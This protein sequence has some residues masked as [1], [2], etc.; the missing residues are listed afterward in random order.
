MGTCSSVDLCVGRGFFQK[1]LLILWLMYRYGMGNRLVHMFEE[2]G[3]VPD[4]FKVFR[5]RMQKATQILKGSRLPPERVIGRLVLLPSSGEAVIVGDLH[6]DLRS[7]RLILTETRFEEKAEQG[8]DVYLVCLGDYVDRGPEQIEVLYT[9]LGLLEA[10]P[11]KVFLFRGN[12]EGPRDLAVSPH[13]FP[14]RLSERYGEDGRLAYASV[15]SLFEQLY[16]SAIIKE[17]A[18]LVHGGI[19]TQASSLEDIA[20]AHLRH[21]GDSRLSEMLWNDPSPLPGFTSSFRGVG[22]LFGLDVTE[23]FLDDLGVKILIRGHESFAE[24]YHFHDGLILSLFSCK[25]PQ[26]GNRHGAYLDVPLDESF[27]AENLRRFIHLF[28]E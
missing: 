20:Y 22:K 19:P 2:S 26:Y 18:F 17:R 27:D 21:P 9:L 23:K 25:I 16:T 24:G 8:E 7:L 14:L 15:Q 12:H 10:Y 11:E 4:D 3:N 6:G 13:D 1:E 5:G 28:G